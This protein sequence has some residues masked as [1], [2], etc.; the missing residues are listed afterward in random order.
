M[1]DIEKNDSDGFHLLFRVKSLRLDQRGSVTLLAG[2]MVFLVTIFGVIALDTNKAIYNR[3]IAQNAVDSAADAAVLWQARSCNMLQQLNNLHYD[4]DLGLCIAQGVASA[5]CIASVALQI[6]EKAAA[7]SVILAP[8]APAIHVARE[9]SC[10]FCA[11]LPWTDLAQQLFYKAIMPI[12][13]AIVV[14]TPYISFGYANACAKGSGADTL[15]SAVSDTF[16][17]LMSKLGTMLGINIPGAESVGGAVSSVLG[18]IPIYAVP[19]DPSSFGLFDPK[20]KGLYVKRKDNDGSPPLYWP[21]LVGQIGSVAGKIGCSDVVVNY[22]SSESFAKSATWDG[23]WGWDDQYFFGHP[24]FNTWI[25]GKKG[26]DELLGLGNLKWL[27]GGKQSSDQFTMYTGSATGG[28]SPLKIPGFIAIASSQ[29]EGTPVIA[30]GDV[31][32]TGKL[33]KVYIPSG[34]SPKEADKFLIYH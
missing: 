13:E 24:G 26:A 30:K 2:M 21:P 12:Q 7:A 11:L 6:A 3:I 29:V 15:G 32:A 9:V 22:S 31:N 10:G 1:N 4:V 5:A 17:G 19:L 8:A 27:N 23:K 25:A 20:N 28:N 34:N 18:A 14:A 33:I 16:G